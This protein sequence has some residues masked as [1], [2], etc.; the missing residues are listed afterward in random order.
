MDK[1]KKIKDVSYAKYGYFFIAPFFIAFLIFQLIPL[2]Q[3]IY[4]SFFEYYRSG[5][6]IIGPNPVG[7]ANYQ[8]LVES[9]FLKYAGNT[10]IMW[11]IGFVPQIIVSLILAAWFT[12]VRLRIKGKQFFKVVIYMPNLIMASA[13]AMLFF[14]LFSDNGPVNSTLISLGILHQPFRFLS[15]V[16]GTRGLV[17]LMNFL[18]WFGNTTILLMAAV[19]GINPALFEAAELDG[20]SPRQTFFKITLPMIRP[21]LVY[22]LI[23]SMIGGLQ[24]FDVP[25]ILTNAQGSPN[26][27][28]M[29]LIMFLNNHLYSKNYGM[30]GAVSVILF[31]VCAILC[32]LVYF[33]LNADDGMSHGKKKKK[34]RRA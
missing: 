7:F 17:G 32:L 5:L 3:T 21:I 29:T 4:Y 23:T 27:S 20:C 26:R 25:Q 33:T 19:M 22:V 14:A 6:K 34:A 8:A 31:I 13:F 16:W 1:G 15:T 9:G 18:M 28:T 2:G 11:L 12:D 30:A 10:I 24:M